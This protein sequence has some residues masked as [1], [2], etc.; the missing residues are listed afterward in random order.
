MGASR[1]RLLQQ[2]T[3]EAVALTAAGAALGLLVARWAVEI[4]ASVAPAQLADQKYT[5]LDWRVIGF[6]TALA[7]LTG[8][9]FGVLPAW[10]AGQLHPT[11][12]M[13]RSRVGSPSRT[14]KR[15]RTWLAAMQA[16]LTIALLA[17]SAAM[18]RTFL[19]L[20]DTDLGLR[21]A[22]VVSLS[23][24]LQGS[25]YR[26]GVARRQYYRDALDRLRALPGVQS[27][28]AI[29]YLPLGNHVYMSGTV[30]L[31]SGQSVTG[32]IWN[33]VMS[34]YFQ[35]VGTNLLA[36]RD[37]DPAEAARPERGVIVNQAFASAAGLDTAIVGRLLKAP[38]RKAPYVIVGLVASTR[39][40]GPSYP[41]DPQVFWPTDEEPPPAL[42]F[43]AK[44]DRDAGSRLAAAGSAIRALDREVAIYD[45]KTLDQQ[46][47]DVLAR[48]RFYTTAI[49]F[50][51]AFA[52][53]LAAVGAYG[54]AAYSVAQRKHEMGLRM[55]LGASHQ[56]IRALVVRENLIPLAAGMV[57]GIAAAA[58]SGRFLDSLVVYAQPID[59][60]A[61]VAGAAVLLL[62]GFAA[63]WTATTGVLAIAP[64]DALRAE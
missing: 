45:L 31:D 52:L 32:S 9:V 21:P 60:A 43:V 54:N 55:A 22:N 50:L 49:V 34:G 41:A 25:K 62:A 8:L 1:G 63:L 53:L 29:G 14:T 11:D 12:P 48:P 7:I 4:A 59:L 24:S 2:L 3:T 44:V 30:K 38:W 57:A 13:I 27:A 42:T 33:A 36:G 17:S 35:T 61:C 37:F 19:N 16:A 47:S 5:I 18:G 20:L 28:G 6:A 64:A 10:M 58:A 51:A 26:T 23:V 15:M 39:L 46:L 40:A 56:E